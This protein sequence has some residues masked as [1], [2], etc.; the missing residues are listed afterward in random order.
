MKSILI[1]CNHT[2]I[3]PPLRRS[4]AHVVKSCQMTVVADGYQAFAELEAS[5][6]DLIIVDSKIK[7]LDSLEL[8][9]SIDYIDP[10]IPVILMLNRNH[11]SLWGP[12][13]RV[14]SNPISRPFK[15]ITFL[16]LIDTLLHQ[17][18][19]R[20]RDL[21]DSLQSILETLQGQTEAEHVFLTDETGQILISIDKL[22][23]PLLQSL[24]TLA[25]S[26]IIDNNLIKQHYLQQ[27]ETL[28]AETDAEQDHNLYL[29]L[30]LDNL[31]LAVVAQTA[32]LR[33]NPGEVWNY[34]D[35]SAQNIKQAFFKYA[36]LGDDLIHDAI[37]T[38]E[39]KVEAVPPTHILVPLKLES[40]E[41]V[42]E[43]E[44]VADEVGVNWQI[45]SGPATVL[46]RLQNFCQVS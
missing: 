30:I 38:P 22:E 11:K 34:I 24:S 7:G 1:V 16:R 9:E 23:T 3:D 41:I 43:H 4:L 20:Y 35:T 19:E 17:Q 39:E 26:R 28:L 21:S 42:Q 27:E 5:T 40:H 45:I 12:A 36:L 29:T 13:R 2:N 33:L 44:V 31:C 18:L 37:S 25:A 15:P 8:A 14:K 32:T 46:D 6:F 10:G